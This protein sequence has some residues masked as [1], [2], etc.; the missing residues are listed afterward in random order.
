MGVQNKP[1]RPDEGQLKLEAVLD[2]SEL[3]GSTLC[4]AKLL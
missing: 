2:L 3:M 4:Y 1:N